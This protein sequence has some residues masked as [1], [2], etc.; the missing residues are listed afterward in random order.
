MLLGDRRV[1]VAPPDPPLGTGLADDELVLRGAPRVHA[2]VDDER[3]AFG[4]PRLAAGERVLV[5]LRG[6]GVPVDVP[7]HGDPVL[8]ELVPV[9]NDRD[10][11]A[12]SYAHAARPGRVTRSAGALSGQERPRASRESADGA[13]SP[14]RTRR[15]AWA[16]SD[17]GPGGARRLADEKALAERHAP[18]VR[19]VEQSEECG[20]G[21][22]FIPTDV[23]LLFG[24]PTVAL[25]GPWN[26]TDLVKIAPVG[27]GSR[28]SLRVPPRLSG[29][30]ARRRAATT[31]AGRNG[32]RGA[33][34]GRLRARGDRAR[35][36]GQGRAPVLAL[37]PLQRLQ[38]HARGRLGDDPAELRRG[39]RG[40]RPRQG[41]V[42][43]GYSAHEGATRS[44]GSDDKLEVVDGTQAG[45]CIRRPARTRTSTARRS[46]SAARR[47]RAS[48]ATTPGAASRALAARGDDPE[49]PAAA[50]KAFPWIAFEGRW[51]E[52]QKA[53]FNGPT[54]P[55]M[56]QQW[57][58]PITW[59]DGWSDRSYAV[60]TGG[61]FGTSTTDFFCAAVATGSSGLIRLLRNPLPTL[62]V[63]G[64]ILAL[65]I[66]AA[67]RATWTPVAPYASAAAARGARS[68]R[69]RRRCT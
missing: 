26:R 34:A 28:R 35:P 1:H 41:S 24:E 61:F 5:E 64:A 29:R 48:A 54:G 44:P 68:C 53:F 4:E 14:D 23:D 12:S 9:G 55:N 7:A 39:G 11:E 56:K 62:L 22:P 27:A 32:S 60:P 21:E 36:P 46:G 40:G 6:R 57:T 38:Q 16:R 3:A 69:R 2:R 10:H 58:Q 42:E 51:G 65:A 15:R 50:E 37:L 30:S 19:I 43:V 59:S 25:R 47:K 67:Y 63:V 18:I 8:R 66:F 31:S 52:L 20:H 33:R 45:R 17:R 13:H 49:R